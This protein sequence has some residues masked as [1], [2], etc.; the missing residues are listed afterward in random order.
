MRKGMTLIETMI[1]MVILGII[2]AA[3]VAVFRGHITLSG[4]L[5]AQQIMVHDTR[6]AYDVL[7]RELRHTCAIEHGVADSMQFRATVSGASQRYKYAIRG[8]SLCREAGGGGMQEVVPNASLL[9]FRYLAPDGIEVPL[10]ITNAN[11]ERVARIHI[12]LRVTLP[13]RQ[14][15]LELSGYIAPRNMR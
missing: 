10:P 5:Q 7:A 4:P 14:D 9:R 13:D 12:R 15:S 8:R 2:G 3:L 6:A 11:D 1:A